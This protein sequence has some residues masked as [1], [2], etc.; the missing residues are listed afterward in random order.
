M[1]YP[2]KVDDFWKKS[3]FSDFVHFAV[4]NVVQKI[5]VKIFWVSQK[6]RHDI[7]FLLKKT[8]RKNIEVFSSYMS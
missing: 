7:S 2:L 5:K 4:K 8:D 6:N 3:I 1:V